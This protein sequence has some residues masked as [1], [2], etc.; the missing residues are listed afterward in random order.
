M[1]KKNV[2]N[3]KNI[4]RGTLMHNFTTYIL[5]LFFIGLFNISVQATSL[6]PNELMIIE[7]K[8]AYIPITRK[9]LWNIL[10]PKNK[11]KEF[12]IEFQNEL[13]HILKSSLIEGDTQVNLLTPQI[14]SELNLDRGVVAFHKQGLVTFKII[15]SRAGNIQRDK[16]NDTIRK[17]SN[18]NY[19]SHRHNVFV[20][21]EKI[22]WDLNTLSLLIHELSHAA[23]DQW[24]STHPE[25]IKIM[26]EG[27]LPLKAREQLVWEDEKGIPQIDGDLYDLLSE[28][29]AFELEYRLNRE[30]TKM[31]PSW[32]FNFSFTEFPS[33]QYDQLING[34][35]RKQYEIDHPKLLKMPTYKLD[36]ILQ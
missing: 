34:Y 36:R 23:F 21:D 12:P 9:I 31:D 22:S 4:K 7:Q 14:R 8:L 11:N 29:Y 30:I 17:L 28:R 26:L 5:M 3:S 15:P 32:P 33:D 27:L 13:D 10:F 35:V 19:F 24:F 6:S 1:T 16:Q 18:L 2:I 20:N 25:N